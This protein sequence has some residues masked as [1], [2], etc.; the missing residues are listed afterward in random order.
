M[1]PEA[2]IE[3]ILSQA[4]LDLKLKKLPY[5]IECFDNSNLQGTHPVSA[6]VVFRN[7]K[8]SKKD[9]RHFNIQTVDGI[10]DCCK[11]F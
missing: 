2:H 9:Y 1:D 11:L 7:G 10:D 4:K 5:H 6:C 8:P 3:R